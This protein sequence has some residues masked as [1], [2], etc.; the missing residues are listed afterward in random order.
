MATLLL[1]AVSATLGVTAFSFFGWEFII[2][3]LVFLL[4]VFYRGNACAVLLQAAT[5]MLF[6][7]AAFISEHLST[8]SFTGQET[9]FNITLSEMPDIDGNMLRGSVRSDTGEKLQLRYIIK[10]EDEKLMLEQNMEPGLYCSVQGMLEQPESRRNENSFDYQQYLRQQGTHWILKAERFSLTNCSYGHNNIVQGIK[11]LRQKGLAYIERNFP[12][13]SGGYVAALLFGEQKEI[14]ENELTVFQKLGLVHLL[15]ISGLHVSFLSGLVFYSGIRIGITRERMSLSILVLLPIYVILSGASPSVW[16]ACLMTMIFFLLSYYKKSLSISKSIILVYLALLLLQPYMLFNIGFQLSF[17]AAFSII[18]SGQIIKRYEG[19]LVQLFLVSLICQMATLPILL[20]HF[21]EVTVLGVFLN[22][23]FVPLYSLLLPYSTVTLAIH[24]CFPPAGQIF[25]SFLSLIIS[26]SNGAANFASKLPL[27]SVAFGKPS[28]IIMI[29]LVSGML[30]LFI[31]WDASLRVKTGYCFAWMILLLFFQ[32]HIEKLDPTGEIAFIDVGQGDSVFIRLPFDKGNYLIDTGG[33]I[34][35]EQ[36]EW[37]RRRSSF[38]T[39]TDII[40]PFLKSKGIGRLDKLI[41]THPDADHIGSVREVAG[42]IG[43]SEMIIG[44]GSEQEYLKRQFDVL[45]VA[46]NIRVKTVQMGNQWKAGAYTFY[47]LNPFRAEEDKNE[48]SIVI[49]AEL[50][51]KRWLFTGDLGVEG[52]EAIIRR[53]PD[54]RAD[55]L[56]A[57]HHGSKTST[58][59][60]LLDVLKPTTAIISAGKGN[61]YGHPHA[62]VTKSLKKR[63]IV[64]YR[65]DEN[66]GIT[67]R[68]KG[69]QGTFSTVL[70]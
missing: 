55:I 29:L 45:A 65:T 57:G 34:N 28:M 62:Q 32:L 10:A 5:L 48:S 70:P 20:F 37:E 58:S 68:F 7:T 19:K 44:K 39:G 33:R 16:R 43:V 14:N 23:L 63:K 49:Y 69:K 67:Y 15:A 27:A 41:L 25:L 2:C 53:Y 61:R 3:T 54:I 64:V 42:G 51:G 52:E 11:K 35:F 40:L 60:L 4:L 47:I 17:A 12:E 26:A 46:S 50:G 24:V 6:F 18:L 30:L 66:G 1:M 31:C 21:Y 56:K 36:E 8:T 13:D 22:V 9:S 38:N 59:E